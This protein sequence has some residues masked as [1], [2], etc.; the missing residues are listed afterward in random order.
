M[1]P[2]TAAATTIDDMCPNCKTRKYFEKNMTFLVN[3]ECYHKLCESCVDRIFSAGPAPC[4]IAGCKRTLRKHR[5]RRQTFDD[6][7]VEREVDIRRKVAEVCNRRED[8]FESLLAYNNYLEDVETIAFELISNIDVPE[9]ERKLT[10]IQEQYSSSIKANAR[11]EKDESESLQARQAAEKEQAKLRKIRARK[12][13]EDEAREKEEGASRL[14]EQLAQGKGSANSIVEEGQRLKRL[15]IAARRD[16]EA[17]AVTSTDGKAFVI[18]GLKGKVAPEP[19]MP[20]DSFGGVH[21]ENE[22]F[23]TSSEHEY[24]WDWLDEARTNVKITAG[25]YDANNYTYRALCDG[26]AGLGVIIG[27]ESMTDADAMQGISTNGAAIVA[28]S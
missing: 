23:H 7:K 9:N 1:P 28:E 2:L 13:A 26:F 15:N 14:I 12:A 16:E 3:P 22:Y 8:E 20:Y 6:I 11:R 21:F 17:K 10:V 5:F 27:N 4:P 19:D 18:H 25:G 24:K